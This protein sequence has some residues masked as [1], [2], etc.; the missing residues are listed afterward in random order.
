MS[1]KHTKPLTYRAYSYGYLLLAVHKA[2]S[3]LNKEDFAGPAFAD[4]L[5]ALL[6]SAFA[7]E[8]FVNHVG[9]ESFRLWKPIKDKLSA[10]DKL[11]LIAEKHGVAVDWSCRPESPRL[12]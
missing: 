12:L 2:Q 1:S 8:A 5:S 4:C 6:F 11:D 9:K 10:C 3:R 7:F